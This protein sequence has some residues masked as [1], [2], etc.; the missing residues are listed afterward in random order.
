VGPSSVTESQV[1]H[2]WWAGLDK[3]TRNTLAQVF[4]GPLT[5]GQVQR[6]RDADL[7]VISVSGDGMPA[8]CF[9]GPALVGY[10][11]VLRLRAAMDPLDEQLL[12][13][14][15]ADWADESRP[16]YAQVPGS[17]ELVLVFTR[18]GGTYHVGWLRI[19]ASGTAVSGVTPIADGSFQQCLNAL[20]TE[21]FDAQRPTSDV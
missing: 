20:H 17:S 10:L 8:R 7:P 6:L 12:N 3:F 5:A 15:D 19:R 18:S 9:M 11:G 13:W 14:R 2:A 21:H 1:A 16:G 4:D